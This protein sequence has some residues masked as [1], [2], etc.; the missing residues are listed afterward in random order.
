MANLS[1]RSYVAHAARSYVAHASVAAT[2]S[3]E[4]I[5]S[6]FKIEVRFLGGLTETQEQAF[7]SA[8]DRWSG[9]ITGDLPTVHVDNED[10][11]DV[12]I[13]ARG[14]HIDGASNVLGQAGPT[15]L[16]PNSAGQYAMLPAKG[17]M[18]FDTDD[19]LEMESSGTLIDVI[20]HEMGHVLGIGTIWSRKKLLTG[21]NSNNPTFSGKLTKAEY[22][23]MLGQ[24]PTAVPVENIGGPGTRNSHWRE[25]IF[26]NEL[27]SGFIATP[28]NPLSILTVASLEDLGYAVDRTKAEPYQLP[29]L[30]SL[31]E[32][33]KARPMRRCCQTNRPEPIIL[34][35]NAIV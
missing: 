27:M 18:T 11:D 34:P 15:V 21:A 4:L 30:R 28:N 1:A 14:D 16:R 26:G 23:K 19:L 20:T 8:A 6:A 5:Q 24:K 10:I 31:E 33:A 29:T 13:L 2:A 32:L 12:L 9:V 25:S 35:D 7:Q 3:P 17:E 22:G